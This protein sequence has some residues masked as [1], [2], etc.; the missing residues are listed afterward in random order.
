MATGE[1]CSEKALL[2]FGVEAEA[3]GVGK[4]CKP[5]IWEDVLLQARVG[6]IE[7]DSE[8]KGHDMASSQE[9]LWIWS[10]GISPFFKRKNA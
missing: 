10:F 3:V 2:E 1:W 9:W 5:P 4:R 7:Q 8:E 6:P